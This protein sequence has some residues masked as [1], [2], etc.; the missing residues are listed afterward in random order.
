LDAIAQLRRDAATKADLAIV[1]AKVDA[2]RADIATH[3]EETREGFASLGAELEG[4]SDPIHK[5]LEADI[6]A[7]HRPLVRAKVPGIP[8]D[9]P[10]EVRAKSGKSTAKRPA[11]R[12]RRR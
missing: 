1:D 6:R 4:H 3:R 10:S 9:L 11:A 8:V 5:D 7:L 12:A 2:V